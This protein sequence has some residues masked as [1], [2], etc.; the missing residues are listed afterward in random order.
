MICKLKR[1]IP[2]VNTVV[3]LVSELQKV[4]MNTKTAYSDNK[5]FPYFQNLF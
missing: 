5:I 3:R 2:N 1:S 4:T